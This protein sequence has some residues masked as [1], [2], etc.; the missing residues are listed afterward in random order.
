[1]FQNPTGFKPSRRSRSRSHSPSR[2]R[3][4]SRSPARTTR[5]SSSRTVSSTFIAETHN[6][7]KEPKLKEVLEVRLVPV[8]RSM[9]CHTHCWDLEWLF[10]LKYCSTDVC[11]LPEFVYSGCTVK[12]MASEM[13]LFNRSSISKQWRNRPVFFFCVVWINLL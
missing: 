4:R 12:C 5:R 8:V 7:R 9:W 10:V 1:M 3:S 11:L 6:A 2:R 13:A